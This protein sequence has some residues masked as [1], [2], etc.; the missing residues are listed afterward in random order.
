M[1]YKFNAH[2]QRWFDKINGNTYHSVSIVNNETGEV[3][4]CPFQYGYEDAYRQTAL[5][6][7]FRHGWI[8]EKYKDELYMFEREN[9]YPIYWTVNDGLKRECINNG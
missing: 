3:I 9:D 6:A 8:P 4:R 5:Q 1:K 7:M 2:G